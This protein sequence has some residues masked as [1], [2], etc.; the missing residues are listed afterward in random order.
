MKLIMI[1]SVRTLASPTPLPKKLHQCS[2]KE[3]TLL[4]PPPR[5]AHQEMRLSSVFTRSRKIHL[6]GHYRS[7][8][9]S[10]NMYIN[11]HAPPTPRIHASVV[12]TSNAK[13]AFPTIQARSSTYLAFA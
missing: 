8:P 7:T 12:R 13:V 2:E 5:A 11:S 6:S 3:K 10:H 9:K 4:F 1:Y